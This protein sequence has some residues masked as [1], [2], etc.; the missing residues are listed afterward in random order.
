MPMAAIHFGSCNFFC[1][2][3]NGNFIGRVSG[4][5][6]LSWE[7]ISTS[8]VMNP[9]ECKFKIYNAKFKV[10]KASLLRFIVLITKHIQKHN[11]ALT[12]KKGIY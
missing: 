12:V 7:L 6:E 2:G 4:K 9:V 3:N 10:Q 5:E 11:S 1:R 8:K